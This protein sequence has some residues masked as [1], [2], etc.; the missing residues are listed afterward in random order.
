MRCEN[1]DIDC[2]TSTKY[3]IE[4]LLSGC[5]I[6]YLSLRHIYRHQLRREVGSHYCR[7]QDQCYRCNSSTSIYSCFTVWWACNEELEET[8]TVLDFIKFVYSSEN[9]STYFP[10]VFLGASDIEPWSFASEVHNLL[11]HYFISVFNEI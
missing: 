8:M 1:Q 5:F 6:D 10:T 7:A 3:P 2:K 9:I 11:K 4:N